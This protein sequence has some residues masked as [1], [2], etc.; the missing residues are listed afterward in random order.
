MT[1]LGERLR[2]RIVGSGPVPVSTFM[3]EALGD[4]TYGYYP[5]RD[6]LGARGDFTTAPEI[7]Q[8]FGELIGLWSVVVWQSMGAPGEFRLIELGPGRGTLMADFLRAA[9]RAVPAFAAAADLH[10]VETSPVLRAAQAE[11]LSGF[12]PNWHDDLATVPPGPSIAVAN[13]FFDAL[14]VRQ[15]EWRDGAWRERL[16]D[17]TGDRFALVLSPEPTPLAAALPD[18]LPPPR[19][20]A[21]FE[22]AAPAQTIGAALGARLAAEGGAALTIDYGHAVPGYGDTLQAVAAHRYADPLADPGEA[23]LT[24]HVDFATLGMTLAQA[25]AT[26]HGPTTQGAFLRA[27][28]IEARRESL[29]GHAGTDQKAGIESGIERLISPDGMGTLFKVLAATAPGLPA[30]PGFAP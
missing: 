19:A 25:G 17:W 26:I 6:P 3:A 14:P 13:E 23:D 20:G 8:A 30:P 1:P 5:T 9:G 29:L 7:S 4:P 2:R 22:I 21:V 24:V 16:V 27:L 11:R 28:G 12:E 15:I 18:G 10:L